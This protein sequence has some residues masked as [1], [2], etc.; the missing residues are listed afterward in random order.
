MVDLTLTRLRWSATI[1]ETFAFS[2]VRDKSLQ[3]SPQT[4][5]SSPRSSQAFRGRKPGPGSSSLPPTHSGNSADQVFQRTIRVRRLP[6]ARAGARLTPRCFPTRSRLSLPTPGC[7]E[8]RGCA[9]ERTS[10]QLERGQ[11]RHDW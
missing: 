5:L 7:P 8:A 6:S 1:D 2:L 11:A 3:A 9:R 10:A 4:V